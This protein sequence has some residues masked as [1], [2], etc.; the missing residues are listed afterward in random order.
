MVTPK[1]CPLC[2]KPAHGIADCYYNGLSKNFRT[3]PV[4]K[5]KTIVQECEV[6]NLGDLALTKVGKVT[7]EVQTDANEK[8]R[9]KYSKVYYSPQVAGNL[10]GSF[11]SVDQTGIIDRSTEGYLLTKDNKKII[12]QRVR[13]TAVLKCKI[14]RRLVE[15]FDN[16]EMATFVNDEGNSL[17]LLKWLH[18]SKSEA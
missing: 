3:G 9:I 10:L 6:A 17:H 7:L 5:A 13:N 18:L 11:P 15:P 12:L 2:N 4:R 16:V 14:I 1:L 8:L